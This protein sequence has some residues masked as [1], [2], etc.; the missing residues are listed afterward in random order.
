MEPGVSVIVTVE[1][2]LSLMMGAVING[3]GGTGTMIDRRLAGGRALV[4]H[5]HIG[6]CLVLAG[7]RGLF[8]STMSSWSVPMQL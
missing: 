5:S 6:W 1:A 2:V 4:K 8:G 7:G 3:A